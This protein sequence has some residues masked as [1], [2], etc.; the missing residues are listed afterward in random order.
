MSSNSS[1]WCLLVT[2]EG[3]VRSFV[4]TNKH[5]VMKLVKTN[6]SS[7]DFAEQI[8]EFIIY[9]DATIFKKPAKVSIN[10]NETNRKFRGIALFMSKRW[11]FRFLWLRDEYIIFEK[12]DGLELY[13]KEVFKAISISAHEVRH[14]YQHYN[15]HTM[16]SYD[17]IE[18]ANCFNK[19]WVEY[20]YNGNISLYGKN[21]TVFKKEFD[22]SLIESIICYYHKHPKL[23]IDLVVELVT[24]NQENIE[25]I[26]LQLV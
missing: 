15:K 8:K 10:S 11:L 17:F 4:V 18:K 21:T 19:A 26:F 25:K 2:R 22:A 16:I 6:I 1:F 9:L 3:T 5:I 13:R 23:T 12:S 24:C 14:R 20:V 7:M